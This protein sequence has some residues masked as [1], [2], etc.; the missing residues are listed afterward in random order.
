MRWTVF[1][2]KWANIKNHTQNTF[3]FFFPQ[4]F[5]MRYGTRQSSRVDPRMDKKREDWLWESQE[6]QDRSHSLLTLCLT[7][8]QLWRM[9]GWVS[10]GSHPQRC[11]H[12]EGAERPPQAPTYLPCGL[13]AGTGFYHYSLPRESWSL[14]T[15]MVLLWTLQST[16]GNTFLLIPQSKC[17]DQL[18]EINWETSCSKRQSIMQRAEG[19]G[20]RVVLFFF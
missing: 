11:W 6:D 8:G 14:I 1:Y 3:F 2:L 12:W 4:T 16:S 20:F 15:F 10:P 5:S 17:S 18:I 7:R 9:G 19:L 13:I